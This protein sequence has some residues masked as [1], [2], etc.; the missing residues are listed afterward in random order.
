M[1]RFK[2]QS[3]LALGFPFAKKDLPFVVSLVIATSGNECVWFFALLFAMA[4]CF[5]FCF[6]CSVEISIERAFS[7]NCVWASY[8]LPH[9]DC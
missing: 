8:G 4:I 7:M 2:N 6:T 5:E 9:S 3:G 1:I